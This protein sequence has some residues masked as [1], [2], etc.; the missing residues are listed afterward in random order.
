MKRHLW[1][2]TSSFLVMGMFMVDCGP[3]KEEQ[4]TQGAI[5]AMATFESIPTAIP[6]PTSPPTPTETQTST[7]T[8]T[9]TE[10]AT[11]APTDTPTLT[12]EPSPTVEMVMC[13]PQNVISDKKKIE[14]IRDEATWIIKTGLIDNPRKSGYDPECIGGFLWESE[15]RSFAASVE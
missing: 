2:I 13:N 6:T 7:P 5:A 8:Q 10:T 9:Q 3:S 12:P 1:L 4:A 14:K 15:I 11:P